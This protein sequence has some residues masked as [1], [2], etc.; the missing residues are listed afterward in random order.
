MINLRKILV[1]TD[2]SE[3]SLAAMEYASSL[4]L[5][6]TSRLYL[7]YVSEETPLV[8]PTLHGLDTDIQALESRS[9]NDA[10]GELARFVTMHVK[11]DWKVVPVVRTGSPPEEIN[12]FA[13]EEGIDLIVMATHGRTG[14]QHVLLGSIAEKIVRTSMVPVL[15]VKP[16]PVREPL[17]NNEDIESELHLR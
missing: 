12:K 2:L 7:L 3:F 5:L 6:F 15:T 14:F 17:I 10:Q 16:H 4:G 8:L 13:V 9:P 1:T 11:P